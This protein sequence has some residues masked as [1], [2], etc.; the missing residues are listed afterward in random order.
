MNTNNLVLIIGLTWP[1]PQTTAAGRRMLQL[2][3]SMLEAGYQL[4]F[5]SA[6]SKTPFSEDLTQ[7]GIAEKPIQLNHHSFNTYVQ[8]LQPNWVL[9]DRFIS[10]EQFGW[11]V[12]EACPKALCILDTED[13]HL[14]RHAREL[15]F[16]KS[17]EPKS[18]FYSN[19]AKREIA[20]IYRSDISLMISQ[21]EIELLTKN[22]Q[23]PASLLYYL[24]FMENISDEDSLVGFE[25]RQH[26]MSIGNL[27]HAPNA[28]AIRYLYEE[29]W[30][31]IRKKIPQA[32]IHVFGAYGDQGIQQLHHPDIGFLIK[33]HIP[34]IQYAFEPYR[35][36]LSPLRFGAGQK[37][38]LIDSMRF[39]T[40]NITTP[41]GIESMCADPKIW[42][43]LVAT[44][45]EDFVAAAISLYHDRVAWK[46]AQKRG[47]D[48]LQDN[49][50]YCNWSKQWIQTMKIKEK[51]LES[52]RANNFV[53]Q[54]LQHH[55]HASTKYLSKWIEG[56]HSD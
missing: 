33:G 38:K 26:F 39:G 36:C 29:V 24:P 1:E 13:L 52:H 18:F 11:R 4:H 28:D 42:N 12:R 17:K 43:G 34:Q 14:L 54:M 45:T 47:L 48:L 55:H 25:N 31:H 8:E 27:K 2:L 37:G 35:I 3:H 5:A 15:A 53:G 20:S 41:I 30:P 21:S 6:A 7:L 23:V 32:E 49:F 40:P 9:F 46:A 22:F 56:K 50:N 10:E 51:Q 16:K 44:N 19:I